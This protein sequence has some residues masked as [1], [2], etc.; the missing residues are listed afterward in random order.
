MYIHHTRRPHYYSSKFHSYLPTVKFIIISFY[1]IFLL[2]Y[3]SFVIK[4]TN[5]THPLLFTQL[6]YNIIVFR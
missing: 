6:H 5:V 2:F 1:Q 3:L 4:I